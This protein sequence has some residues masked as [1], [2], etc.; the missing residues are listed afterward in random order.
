MLQP[1]LFFLFL[2]YLSACTP[3]HHSNPFLLPLGPGS[4]I[5]DGCDPTSREATRE[6]R[7]LYLRNFREPLGAWEVFFPN[8]QSS[9]IVILRREC[10]GAFLLFN[11]PEISERQL[12]AGF[13]YMKFHS[14]TNW[15]LQIQLS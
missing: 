7:Q 1:R 15:L 8:T 3:T 13:I 2:V 9:Q 4:R 11:Q 12:D 6:E 5:T 14:R 10:P